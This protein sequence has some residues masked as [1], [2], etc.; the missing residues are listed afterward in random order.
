MLKEKKKTQKETVKKDE[1][2]L[3]VALNNN[4]KTIRGK[5]E[6]AL[7]ELNNDILSYGKKLHSLRLSIVENKKSYNFSLL[8]A[9]HYITTGQ[10]SER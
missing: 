1:V 9:V 3:Y 2:I 8:S 7:K 6:I 5:K 10:I 4:M